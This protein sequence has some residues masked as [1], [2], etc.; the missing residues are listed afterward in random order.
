MWADYLREHPEHRHD[1]PPSDWFGDSA[2]LSDELLGLVLHG[3]K[4]ATAASVE[5]YLH[6]GE[7]LP[8]IGSHWVAHDG[9][10]RPRAVIR[11]IELRIG[12]LDSVDAQFAWDE[13]E[14]DRS[15]ESWLRH[16]R[17]Y[18]QRLL[19]SIGLEFHEQMETMFERF[20]VVWPPEYADAAS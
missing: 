9:D 5:E 2:A 7:P 18:F 15:L 12:P 13:G 6:T 14:D 10:G 4:R 17:R 3:P 8:R 11:S 19:P 20:R 1:E 16:H